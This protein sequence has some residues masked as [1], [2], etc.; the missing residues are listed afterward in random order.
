M[1]NQNIL[2]IHMLCVSFYYHFWW[3]STWILDSESCNSTPLTMWTC[4]SQLPPKASV[5]SSAEWQ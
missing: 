4:T 1:D 2:Y 5:S 3:L